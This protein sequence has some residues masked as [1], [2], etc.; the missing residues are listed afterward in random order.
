M[1]F[2]SLVPLSFWIE[3][4][5]VVTFIIAVLMAFLARKVR[6]DRNRLL[7][8]RA[9]INAQSHPEFAPTGTAPAGLF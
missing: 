2:L 1:Q 6:Y 5:L 4:L 7:S 8:A 9:E 3:P